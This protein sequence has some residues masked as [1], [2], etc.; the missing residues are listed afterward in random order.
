MDSLRK[1]SVSCPP[2]L[3]PYKDVGCRSCISFYRQSNTAH[4]IWACRKKNRTIHKLLELTKTGAEGG[5]REREGENLCLQNY[6]YVITLLRFRG[7]L[8]WGITS[9]VAILHSSATGK[10]TVAP[11]S[12]TAP[13]S[14]Y[15]CHHLSIGH[16]LPL[17]AH[18]PFFFLLSLLLRCQ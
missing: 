11:V 7:D 4:H 5:G 17:I 8:H 6:H 1:L 12:P 14:C 18:A 15:R 16:T 13:A 9:S 2:L 10:T 3:P